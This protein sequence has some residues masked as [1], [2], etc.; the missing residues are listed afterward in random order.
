MICDV[1]CTKY[2]YKILSGGCFNIIVRNSINFA[3]ESNFGQLLSFA[4]LR[5]NLYHT[6]PFCVKVWAQPPTGVFQ[7]L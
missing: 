2:V 4:S 1:M 6:Y 7:F 5:K 3:I